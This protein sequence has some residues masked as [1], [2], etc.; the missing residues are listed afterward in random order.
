MDV[1][2]RPSDRETF[3][4]KIPKNRIFFELGWPHRPMSRYGFDIHDARLG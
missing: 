1:S 3:V 4:R 2:L